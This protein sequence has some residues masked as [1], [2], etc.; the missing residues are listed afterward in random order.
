MLEVP[1][2]ELPSLVESR[3]R[4]GPDRRLLLAL[5]VT[6]QLGRRATARTAESRFEEG[7]SRISVGREDVG[8][9]S[10]MPGFEESTQLLVSF[11]ER[12]GL[13]ALG[14]H[15]ETQLVA[16]QEAVAKAEPTPI[17]T[18]LAAANEGV[19]SE[20][21]PVAARTAA[22][23]YAWLGWL[24]DDPMDLADVLGRAW[25][26]VAIQRALT[27]EDGTRNEVLIAQ[28]CS[29]GPG[30]SPRRSRSSGAPRPLAA[31]PSPDLPRTS[32]NSPRPMIP[33]VAKPS[34]NS[35]LGST[36]DRPIGASRPA[37]PGAR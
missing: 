3:Y 26:W 14:P 12:S 8:E 28:P 9:L 5:Q 23:G 30:T 24:V 29:T 10:A 18:A 32:R 16:V 22:S 20:S 36:R 13:E 27:A 35:S 21:G 33:S 15:E 2:A 19:D 7:K 25:A 4:L 34:R 1:P 6:D 17:L 31:R 11:V 37:S